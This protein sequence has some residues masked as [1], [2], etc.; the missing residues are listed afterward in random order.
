MTAED[1]YDR[2][3]EAMLK[4]D[5]AGARD[6]I[7]K[8]LSTGTRPDAIYEQLLWPAMVSIEQMLRDEEISIVS[9]H[10]ATRINRFVADQV[11]AQ[12]VRAEARGKKVLVFCADDEPQELGAQMAGDLLEA[13]GWDCFFVGG[14]VP[15][16]EIIEL[17]GKIRPDL[18]LI[19]GT[20]PSELPGIR[21]MIDRV[22]DIG[23]CPLMNVMVS[24]GI[25]NR[26]D[27]LAEEINADLWAGTAMDA[28]KL[29]ANAEEKMHLPRI[30]GAPKKRRRR[31]AA[32]R[33]N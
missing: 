20:K 10:L 18:T 7:R 30:P 29:A 6:V 31:L 3:L 8:A 23:A 28:V 4:A 17:I 1:M 27:G 25:F 22:R 13:D 9:E 19:Y 24:G 26:V 16:D 11:Q 21:R 2:Y 32:A 5:R 14:G 12:L 33:E 15:E